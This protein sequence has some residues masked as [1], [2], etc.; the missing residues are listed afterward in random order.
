MNYSSSAAQ[1]T[2]KLLVPA[3]S[4][5]ND[6]AAFLELCG[7]RWVLAEFEK[8]SDAPAYMCLSYA[9]GDGKSPHVFESGR[10]MS[11]RTIP[12]LETAINAVQFPNCLSDALTALARQKDSYSEKLAG[13]IAGSKAIWID[14]LCV[15]HQEP[16]RGACLRNMGAIYRSAS[17]VIAVV[18]NKCSAV[19]HK[20]R[21]KQNLDYDDLIAAERD[22]WVTRAWTYQEIAAS[23]LM[24]FAAEGDPTVMVS[25]LDY[26]GALVDAV[27][28]YGDANGIKRNQLADHFPM[29]D[30]VQEL[31]AELQIDDRPA[32]QVISAMNHRYAERDEDKVYAML[33]ALTVEPPDNAAY[34]SARPAELFLN[35]CVAMGDFSFI[36]CAGPRSELPGRR[37]LPIGER[38]TPVVSGLLAFGSGLAGCIKESHLQMNDM[39]VMK[40]G[41]NYVLAAIGNFTGISFGAEILNYLRQKGFTGSG[42]CLPLE[43]GYFFSQQPFKRSKEHIVVIS[44]GVSFTQGAPA[45]LLRSNG[46]DINEFCDVGVFIGR[47][48]KESVSVSVN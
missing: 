47:C 34:L 16:E 10:T 12:V 28:D 40:P 42:D 6:G 30:K 9:W 29:L 46:T 14:A 1:N 41:P 36:F 7:K 44:N 27:T 33:G 35:V 43:H 37:W 45:M 18:S 2:F 17:H 25:H 15:P 21:G 38:L 13:T 31:L 11:D 8:I 20:I 23:Q 26:L 24:L 3:T 32:F 5:V 19:F 39:C 4:G 22:T 48:P